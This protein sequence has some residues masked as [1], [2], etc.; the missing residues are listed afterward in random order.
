MRPTTSGVVLLQT[1]EG[2]HVWEEIDLTGD[3][4]V[5]ELGARG[6]NRTGTYQVRDGQRAEF[7]N[8]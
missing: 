6:F 4:L 2:R 5:P 8:R 7:L 3:K 1:V